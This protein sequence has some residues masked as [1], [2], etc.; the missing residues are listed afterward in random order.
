MLY[1]LI[2]IHDPCIAVLV[3][4]TH[5]C[6]FAVFGKVVCD[7]WLSQCLVVV[8]SDDEIEKSVFRFQWSRGW[9]SSM[10]DHFLTVDDMR[11]SCHQLID[12]FF[13]LERDDSMRSYSTT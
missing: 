10:N 1:L 5:V 4:E 13:F 2:E 8:G 7:V 9:A 6:Y 11:T 12:N 3:D